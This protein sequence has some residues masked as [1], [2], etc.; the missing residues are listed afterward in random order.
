MPLPK[1]NTPTYELTLPSNGKKIKY[2]P[3]LVREEKILI[4]A[5]ETEDQKQI[6]TAIIQILTA[7]IMT[8]SVKLNELATFDI[9][10]LFLNVRSKS[11]GETI[12]LNLICPDDEKTSV[13]VSIDLDSIKV[14]KDSSHTNIVKLDDNLS[15]KLKYP[16]MKQF[17]E[18]NFEAGVETVSNTMD[19]VISSIDMIYNEEESWNASESTK[20]ELGD[21]IDQL[22]TKQFKLIE[23]FFDTMPKLSHKV[24]VKN[25]KTDVESTVLLEGLAAFFN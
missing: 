7:C 16:S 14:K 18:S 3:F 11:V 6:T 13:E 4:M 19:V 9:E 23:N 22:N 15:L 10:Y 24:K 2:R 8:R 17:I 21:F 5:L 12:S 25:P 20:K 1:I